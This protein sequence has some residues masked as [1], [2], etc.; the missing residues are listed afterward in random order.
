MVTEETLTTQVC[1]CLKECSNVMYGLIWLLNG[2][3]VSNCI[4]TVILKLS[5]SYT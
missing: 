1:M 2:L 3:L 4:D 5:S